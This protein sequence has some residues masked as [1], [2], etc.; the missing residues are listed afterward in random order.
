ML[1]CV[2][3]LLGAVEKGRVEDGVDAARPRK[4]HIERVSQQ[5]G[6]STDMDAISNVCRVYWANVSDTRQ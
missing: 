2:V 5:R 4:V 1:C 3:L 6:Y